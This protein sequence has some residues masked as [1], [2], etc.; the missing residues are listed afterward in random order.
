MAPVDYSNI[1]SKTH[2]T[3][4]EMLPES[5]QWDGGESNGCPRY[6]ILADYCHPYDSL[7]EMPVETGCQLLL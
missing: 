1:P 3:H 4:T 2:H 6:E 5:S 7:S